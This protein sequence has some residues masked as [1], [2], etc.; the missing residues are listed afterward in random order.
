[1]EHQEVLDLLENSV[2]GLTPEE[3]SKELEEELMQ[4]RKELMRL[5]EE[6]LVESFEKDGEIYWK[7]KEKSDEEREM[8]KRAFQ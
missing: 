1:M 4:V 2:P 3:L 7:I 6:N 8:E 5:S